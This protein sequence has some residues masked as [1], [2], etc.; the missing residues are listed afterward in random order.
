MILYM[1]RSGRG[2]SLTVSFS[3]AGLGQVALEGRTE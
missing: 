3:E 1:R 2:G